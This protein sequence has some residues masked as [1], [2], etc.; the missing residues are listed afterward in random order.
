MINELKKWVEI[1]EVDCAHSRHNDVIEDCLE[2][3]KIIE[4][5]REVAVEGMQE[6][7]DD[8]N[9]GSEDSYA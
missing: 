6:F 7:Y 5:I 8:Q 3:Q 1:L 9:E 2:I 4:K